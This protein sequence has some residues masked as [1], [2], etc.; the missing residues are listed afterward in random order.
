MLASAHLT[1]VLDI[2]VNST[3]GLQLLTSQ[4]HHEHV[5]GS[6]P[7]PGSRGLQSRLISTFLYF[8]SRIRCSTLHN[9]FHLSSKVFRRQVDLDMILV[10]LTRDLKRDTTVTVAN[11][12]IYLKNS[13]KPRAG[14]ITFIG[15]R[16]DSFIKTLGHSIAMS[17]LLTL[18][19]NFFRHN[20]HK[21][22]SLMTYTTRL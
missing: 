12:T 1:L 10:D 11:L 18:S 3:T 19:S 16:V 20:G 5:Q 6:T 13:L 22:N 7:L 14:F 9:V 8:C 2:S 15:L 17:G 4:T 21:C